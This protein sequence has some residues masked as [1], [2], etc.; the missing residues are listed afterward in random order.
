[1]HVL[2][3][4]LWSLL[5]TQHVSSFAGPRQPFVGRRC[6]VCECEDDSKTTTTT[7]TI[8]TTT[9]TSTPFT[10]TAEE[11]FNETTD[12]ATTVTVTTTEAPTTTTTSAPLYFP[13]YINEISFGGGRACAGNSWIELAI[14]DQQTPISMKGASLVLN[15]TRSGVI[16]EYVFTESS[17]LVGVPYILICG[18]LNPLPGDSNLRLIG[19]DGVEVHETLEIPT[20]SYTGSTFA[21][22]YRTQS[23]TSRD[24]FFETQEPTP[25][26]MNVLSSVYVVF[27]LL[28]PSLTRI[29]HE[30]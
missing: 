20:M 13:V 28:N 10:T 23:T 5:T 2:T 27:D 1:M 22:G 8:Y 26:A 17:P 19:P 4:L 16:T 6:P 18:A 24:G 12:A 14:F 11:T 30:Q 3:L 25:N 9:T 29:P 7:E 15:T 21:Y